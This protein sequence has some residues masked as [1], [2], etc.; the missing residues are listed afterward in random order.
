MKN[1]KDLPDFLSFIEKYYNKKLQPY[2]K[3]ML[4]LLQT[5]KTK[6]I[7]DWCRRVR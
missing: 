7:I 2:Q 6:L 1:S 4:G 3:R 5:D